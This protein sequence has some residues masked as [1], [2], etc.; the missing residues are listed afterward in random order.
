MVCC[1]DPDWFDR[2]LEN[3][4]HGFMDNWITG[5]CK[6]WIGLL[7]IALH[8]LDLASLDSF[9]TTHHVLT[10]SIHVVKMNPSPVTAAALAGLRNS[11]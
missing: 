1:T 5:H 3:H 9:P 7:L 6:V 4:G 2:V 10:L 11:G 8:R